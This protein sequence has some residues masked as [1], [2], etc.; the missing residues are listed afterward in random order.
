MLTTAQAATALGVSPERIRKWVQRGQIK[1]TLFGR[2]R[3]FDEKEIERIKKQ[4]QAKK[5]TAHAA[6]AHSR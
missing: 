3:A 6:T 1:S 4:Q 2:D 5:H